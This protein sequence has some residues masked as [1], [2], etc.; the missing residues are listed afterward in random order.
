MNRMIRKEKQRAKKLVAQI[1]RRLLVAK[2]RPPPGTRPRRSKLPRGALP[3]EEL[4]EPV[5]DD[6]ER[7][8]ARRRWYASDRTDPRPR[9]AGIVDEAAATYRR[10]RRKRRK[11]L[12]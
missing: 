9:V 8:E 2:G 3:L 12:S 6:V 4:P 7:R 11:E 5:R 10:A 1:E